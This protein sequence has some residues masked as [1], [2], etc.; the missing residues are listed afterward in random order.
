MKI[1]L[2]PLAASWLVVAVLLSILSFKGGDASIV[3]GW[4]HLFWTAPFGIVGG[5]GSTTPC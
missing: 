5:S 4:L 3:A 1:P 2:K